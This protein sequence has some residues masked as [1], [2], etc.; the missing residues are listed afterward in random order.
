LVGGHGAELRVWRNGGAEERRAPPLPASMR[1]RCAEIAAAGEK[2]LLE[3]KGYSIAIHYRLAP[4]H[5]QAIRDAVAVLLADA[6]AGEFEA[7]HGKA[8]VEIK[9][10]GLNKG[11]GIRA[12]MSHAP[13]AGRRPVFVGDDI[14]D[15]AGFAVMPEYDG[16]ALV[17]GRAA[18][19]AECRFETP[20]D[21]R[22]WVG[23]LSRASSVSR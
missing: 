16:V 18:K 1:Q 10:A 20:A 13:F 9:R 23:Q 11:E 6:P 3:D 7:L 14:T 8:V 4:Q 12:L 21:V 5:E 19:G 15:E 17:V 2:V 22:D